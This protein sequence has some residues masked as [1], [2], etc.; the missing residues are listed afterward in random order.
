M[1]EKIVIKGARQ[2]NLKNIDVEIPKNKFVVITG[3][4]GSGK[5]SL[6]FDTIYSE[7]QRRYVESLS[8]YARQFIGQMNK[9]EVDSIE[10]LA[11]A[12]SIEQKTTNK[13]PRSTVGTITEIYDYMRLLFAHVGTAHCPICHTAVERQSIEEILDSVL[14]K[15]KNESKIIVLSP[16]VHGKKGTHKN[17]F[18]NLTKKGYVR[19]RVNGEILYLED[20]IELDKNK[21]HSIEVVVDRL[22]VNKEDK[23]FKTRLTED[24]EKTVELSG[25]KIVLNVDEADYSYSENYSCPNH[26]EVSI[27]ELSPRLFSFNAPYGACPECKG[28]GKKLE[29][30]ENKLI[31][32]ENLSLKDGAVY[33]PGAMNR[34]GYS[35]EIFKTMC[36]HFNIDMN[37][38]FKELSS[39]KKEIIYHG[40]EGKK[41]RFDYEGEGFSFNGL[42]EFEGIVKNL[43]RRYSETASESM[44]EEIEA[45]YMVEKLCKLCHGK[46]LKDEVLAVEVDGKNIMEICQLSIRKSLNFFQELTLTP[47]QEKIA[48]EILKEIKERLNFMINVGL[49]YLTLSRETKTLS[50][51][52][53]QR[54]RLATQI[55]SGLTGVLY[56]LDEPSI[57]LHQ[58]DNDKLLVTLSRLRDL[59]NTLI[60][61]EHDE[62]TMLQADY[63][64]DMGPGAGVN[65]GEI[66]FAGTPEEMIKSETSLTGEFLNGKK[67]IV[68]PEKRRVPEDYLTLKGASGN[69]LK[70]LDVKIPKGV[71]TVVT[72]V[73][74][75]GKSTLINHTL[76]PALFNKLNGGKLYPLKYEALEGIEDLDKVIDIDQSPIGRT[77]RSNPATY[78]KIFD[79]IR[80]IFSQT[81][82]AKIKGYDKGRFSFNVKGG[83]CE[84]CQGAGII[85]IEMNFLPDVYV[86]CEV[87]KGKRYNRETLDVFYKGKNISDVLNMSVGEAYEFFA[88]IPSLERKLKVLLDVGLD[89]IKLGQPATT[90]SG[91]EAQRIKLAAELSKMPRGKTIYI[92]DEPTTGLHFE[93]IR[94]LLEVLDRLVEK[95]HTVII[96][97]HN[98]DVIKSADYVIDIGPEGGENGG[99]ILA[100]GTPEEIAKVK[101]SYTGKYI[102]E[103]LKK[104]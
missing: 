19:A 103:V 76:F 94:K 96:I 81:K 45:K 5:S 89:Y 13:N 75:S 50:G 47:K 65:G 38:P 35:W 48:A 101:K 21:K 66:I 40:S 10:G 100:V 17:L 104:K 54:I 57:G 84:A 33:V 46:R 3:V 72:G 59:G 64:L 82:D 36:A 69:N 60:V 55:G 22:I 67:K 58:R 43:E 28:I 63:I 7:G 32:N 71:L 25:G 16:L 70:N 78:T 2:H 20:E 98:L 80:N 51:G 93:D 1:L 79:E 95:N 14:E 39:E 73:S 90:L 29:V 102:K 91:G 8:A 68:V 85:K 49:D 52:E 53:S 27:P 41:F 74:G 31:E 61:V 18:L 92:L 83:R 30:D 34:K 23:D 88:L 62:D 4:S 37:T 6:A 44:R 26:E 9:P 11:P 77:P 97:E 42:R 12:I 56:V 15:F 87:C 24:L 86:E 99:K